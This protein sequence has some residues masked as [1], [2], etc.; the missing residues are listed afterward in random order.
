MISAL[1]DRP[2]WGPRGCLAICTCRFGLGQLPSGVANRLALFKNL[3]TS[4]HMT[5]EHRGCEQDIAV[6]YPVFNQA[7]V[8]KLSMCDVVG[9]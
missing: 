5:A 6:L 8:T 4:G 3:Y 7:F 9:R 2:I 1:I